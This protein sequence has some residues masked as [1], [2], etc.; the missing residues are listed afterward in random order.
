M[1]TAKTLS[2][3]HY[4]NIRTV[5]IRQYK[6]PFSYYS[7]DSEQ[8]KTYFIFSSMITIMSLAINILTIHIT[9]DKTIRLNE[10]RREKTQHSG[11]PYQV[12]HNQAVQPQT[13]TRCLNFPVREVEG[14]FYSEQRKQRRWSASRL[15]RSWSAPLFS[16]RQN[17]WFS[18]DAAQI[19]TYFIVSSLIWVIS[20]AG[21][22]LDIHVALHLN[23]SLSGSGQSRRRHSFSTSPG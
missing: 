19:S 17:C 13:M 4:L 14:L 22:M 3:V 6:T 21:I 11:F 23:N 18:H 1:H 15:P 10:P 7:D 8:T 9:L 12:R 5:R 20:L 2:A 16:H